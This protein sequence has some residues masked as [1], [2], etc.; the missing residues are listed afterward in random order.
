MAGQ[1][2]SPDQQAIINNKTENILV[3]AAAGSA[4]PPHGY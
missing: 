4:K 3:P 1:K 2:P